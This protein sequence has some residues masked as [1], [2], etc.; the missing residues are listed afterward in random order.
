M[1]TENVNQEESITRLNRN[2][3]KISDQIE[4]FFANFMNIEN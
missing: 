4:M 2:I 3:L 1:K